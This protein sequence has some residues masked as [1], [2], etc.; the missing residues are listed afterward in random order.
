MSI[1]RKFV[2]VLKRF[3]RRLYFGAVL[4]YIITFFLVAKT[5]VLFIHI[6]KCA[7]ISI[8][9]ALYGISI[10]HKKLSYFRVHIQ[11]LHPDIL[12]VLRDPIERLVSALN[13]AFSSGTQDGF[14]NQEILKKI[15]NKNLDEIISMIEDQLI[16]DPVFLPQTYY[17]DKKYESIKFYLYEDLARLEKDF[18]IQIPK[19]NQTKSKFFSRK[20]LDAFSTRI[21]EIYKE[22]YRLIENVK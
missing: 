11:R 3:S 5:R 10:G 1:L 12:V 17:L 20:D 2:N 19:K 6:P 15:K 18:K 14:F 9:H 7:G 22:D 16:I 8:S 21:F 13:Y 4:E